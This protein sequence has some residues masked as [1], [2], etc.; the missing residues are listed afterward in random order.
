VKRFALAMLLTVS[1]TACG[2][3]SRE[4]SDYERAAQLARDLQQQYRSTVGLSVTLRPRIFFIDE[5]GE[6]DFQSLDMP[7]L[8][9]EDDTL[10]LR[11]YEKGI[12]ILE[13]RI[14]ADGAYQLVMERDEVVIAGTLPELERQIERGEVGGSLE[15]LTLLPQL[16]SEARRGPVPDCE[17]YQ[18]GSRDG[19]I[20]LRA[21]LSDQL[22][23]LMVLDEDGQRVAHKEIV[24]LDGEQQR[25]LLRIDY[26]HHLRMDTLLRAR[27]MEIAIGPEARRVMIHL[28]KDLEQRP[29]IEDD[30][31][32]LEL[33]EGWPVLDIPGYLAHIGHSPEGDTDGALRA[34]DGSPPDGPTP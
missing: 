2:G 28:H 10:R 33:P 1:W 11:I 34:G 26:S 32:V 22:S 13:G 29:R 19:R 5:D 15:L 31:L 25:V 24:E 17:E 21:M 23:A 12:D 3:P 18:M 30:E 7:I 20:T 4:S 16:R 14:E 9:A 6:E 8:L 27:R